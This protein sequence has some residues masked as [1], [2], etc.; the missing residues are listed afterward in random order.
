MNKTTLFLSII[1]LGNL[2]AKDE[3]TLL[4]PTQKKIIETKEKI[5]QEDKKINEKDWLNDININTT[6]RKNQADEKSK[7]VSISFEQDIFRFGAIYNIIDASKIQEQYD[8]LDL[9]ITFDEYINTIYTNVL[10][11]KLT[12]LN[13]QKQKLSIENETIS[14]EIIKDEYNAGQADVTDLND[15]IMDRNSLEEEL[16]NLQK[17]KQEYISTL[18]Q[19]TH[20]DYNSISIPN[21][22][23]KNLDEYLKDSKDIKLANY[24]EEISKLSYKIKKSD[25]LPRLSLTS[26]YGYDYTESDGEETYNY[27]LR[28]TIPFS[29]SSINEVEK[30]QL[31]YLLAQREKEQKVVDESETY[32]RLLEN[33]KRYEESNKI[34]NRDISLYEELL[35]TVN[36]EY[37]AGYKAIEDVNILSNTKKIRELDIQINKL[38]TIIELISMYY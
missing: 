14:L 11:A 10:N 25:Y 26:S 35:E 9:K 4:S 24:D 19:Y 32:N 2:F 31:E 8:L 12:D 36:T 13:I 22:K 6:I 33:I 3:T 20:L 38:N 16:I 17:T 23:L 29:F 15:T 27:G 34:A 5:I 1:L 7:D 18:K 30:S 28:V 21:L 37:K